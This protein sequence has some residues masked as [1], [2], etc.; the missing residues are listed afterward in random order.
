MSLSGKM[1]QVNIRK[2]IRRHQSVSILLLVLFR[3]KISQ[4]FMGTARFP[5][6]IPMR[7]TSDIVGLVMVFGY[8]AHL[9]KHTVAPPKTVMV[10]LSS[11]I[12]I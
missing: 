12:L 2:V 9:A 8:M 7:G 6:T 4:I 1:E 10:V 11:A 3:R 5:L